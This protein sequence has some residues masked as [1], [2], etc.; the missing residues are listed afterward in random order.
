MSNEIL[1]MALRYADIGIPVMPLHGIKSDGSCICRR[2]SNCSSKGKHPIYS[3]WKELATTN[4]EVIVDWWSKHPH[5]NI[6][7]PTGQKSGWLVLDI[8][9]KY[10]GDKSLELLEMLYDDL[11]PTVTSITGSGGQHHIFK[12]P[13]GKEVPNS[14]SFYQGLDTRS[15]GGLIVATPSI[16]VSGNA[17]RWLEGHSPF[18]REPAEVP[19]WLLELMMKE[20]TDKPRQGGEKTSSNNSNKIAEGSR[21]NHLTS[22]AGA[23]RRKGMSEPGIVAALMVENEVNCEPALEDDEVRTIARSI[24]KYEPASQ[25]LIPYKLNDVGNAERLA[26]LYGADIRYCPEW[27]AWLIYKGYWKVDV[28]GEIYAKARQM[29]VQLDKE[30]LQYED[31]KLTS[32]VTRSG[33]HTHIQGLLNQA[34][35]LVEHGIPVEASM[36]DTNDSLISLENATIDFNL[37]YQ[38][39]SFIV[40]DNQRQ[41]Y[42]TKQLPFSYDEAAKCP[43]WEKFLEDIIPDLQTRLFVQRAIGY[44]ITGS[45]CE[46]KF[47]ILHGSGSNGKSTF[48]KIISDMLGSYAKTIQ[49]ET[50]MKK[51]RSGAINTE[52]AS[53]CGARFVKTSEIEEG[54]KLAESLVKQLTG[55]DTISTRHLFGKDFEYEPTYKIWLSTNHKPQIYGADKGIWR[56]I[57]LIPFEVTIRE[58]DKD[59]DLDKKLRKEI[60]GIFNW[61]LEGLMKW[62]NEGL[63]PPEKIQSAIENYRAQEDLLQGFIDDCIMQ[64]VGALTSAAELYSYYEWYC[65]QNAIVQISTTRFG[66]KIREDKGFVKKQLHGRVYYSDIKIKEEIRKGIK[67]VLV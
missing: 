43:R 2:G 6:G 28:R 24:G 22:L 67:I 20:I 16:H 59:A 14:V 7:I 5:A 57:C 55:G 11:P 56:R 19:E 13:K 32:F 58:E 60:Q 30:A 62:K 25:S 42:I 44:S 65:R 45:T 23:L 10:E 36:W 50:L 52:I 31:K 49:P 29:L 15:E 46:D 66:T 63:V 9:T 40:R 35:T 48:I 12:Y 54:K 4:K 34:K 61:A 1:G 38:D 26:A 3:G 18:D 33:C 64:E 53:I 39:K 27:K 17:Y 41:D 37:K 47:F 21:N 51:E 8:D